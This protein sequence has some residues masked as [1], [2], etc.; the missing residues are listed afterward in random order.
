MS[1]LAEQDSVP[2]CEATAL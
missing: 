1:P 2:P